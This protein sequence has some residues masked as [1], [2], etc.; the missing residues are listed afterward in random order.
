VEGTSTVAGIPVKNTIDFAFS[1]T[2]D[3]AAKMERGFDQIVR[4]F[5]VDSV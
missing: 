2:T 3:N 1:G 5:K 4:I